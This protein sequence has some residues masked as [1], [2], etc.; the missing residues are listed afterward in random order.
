MAEQGRTVRVSGLPTD[1]EDDRLKD[2]LIIHFLRTRNG[3]GEID[4]V[5]IV[6]ARPV[7]ALITFEDSEVAHRVIQQSRHILDVD[8]KTYKLK[9]TEHHESLDPDE[10]I[11]NLS[12]TVDYS[13]LPGGRSALKSLHKSH[14]EV[15]IDY[16]AE[17]LCILSGA[18]SKVQAALAHLLG[19]PRPEEN[20]EAGRVESSSSRS[21][22]T[23]KTS[24]AQESEEQSQKPNKP[25]E[26]SEK[27]HSNRLSDENNAG[28]YRDLEPR[29]DS[30]ED[31][32]QPAAAELHSPEHPTT[33]EDDFPLIVDADMFQYLQKN[34]GKE[35]Q[36]I[37]SQYGVE[38]VDVTNQGLTTLYLQVTTGEGQGGQEQERVV[39][40]RKA[41][42]GLYQKNETKTRRSQLTKSILS[43][44]G[45]LQRAIESLK[46]KLPK[47]LLSEDDRNIY[48]IGSSSDVSEA[49]QFL[50]LDFDLRG[51]KEDVSSLRRYPSYDFSSLSP[52]DKIRVPVTSSTAEVPLN[53]RTD[54]VLRPEDDER[55]AEGAKKYKLAARF[56]DTGLSPLGNR[57]T[58]FSFRGLSSLSRPTRAGPMLGHDVLSEAAG[59]SRAESQNTGDDILFKGG[60]ALH[61]FA[62]MQNKTSL[63]SNVMDT[64]PKSLASTGS[65]TPPPAGSGSTLK[66]AN[67]FS[68]TPQQKAQV[69]SPKSQ[70][71][72]STTAA[73]ARGRS[74]SFSTQTAK[75]RREVHSADITVSQVMWQHIKEAYSAKVDD[76][77]SDVQIKEN[78]PDRSGDFTVTITGANPSI[79]SSCRL[80]LQKL[81]DLVQADFSVHVLHLS[82]L[83]VT[84][85]E[86]ETLQACCAEVQ[87]RFKKVTMQ[88][89]KKSLFLLGP[90]QLCSQVAATLQEVFSGDL[91][92]MRDHQDF[93]STRNPSTSLQLD[94]GH[95]STSLHYDSNPQVMLESTTG[96]ADGTGEGQVRKTKQMSEF[97]E[98][99]LMNGSV[100]QSSVRKDPVIKEKLKIT[101]TMEIDGHHSAAGN[102]VGGTVTHVNGVGSAAACTD[103]PPTLDKKER[104]VNSTQKE[105]TQQRQGQIQDA[106]ESGQGGDL[107]PGICVCGDTGTSVTRTKCGVSMCSKCMDKVHVHCKVCSEAD[108]AETPPGIRGKMRYS[109]LDINLPGHHRDA[110]VKITYN[111]PDG[112]QGAV[113]V[114]PSVGNQKAGGT[115]QHLSYLTSHVDV[116]RSDQRARDHPFP[117]KPFKGG[118]FEAF[119]P[120]CERTRTLLPRLEKAFKR[121]L[122]FT[123]K[124]K[125]T[126][127]KVIWDCIPHKTSLQGG[128]SG[129]GYPD[130][131]YLS[132][133]SQVLSSHGIEESP[134]K[135]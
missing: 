68:G 46:V 56:K 50:L 134:G 65:T 33:P 125:E 36:H 120:D 1:V 22:R 7:S 133:L 130:S 79:V 76:L 58:D 86:D 43:P 39:L 8:G 103:K 97:S 115:E 123:V 44:R 64:R 26:R 21:A 29:G 82:D 102:K 54:Q 38:V 66:R 18:F 110:A 81:V 127:A 105:S 14:P 135:S 59:I 129:N 80:S 122:T 126:G 117:G 42:S 121:G 99:E 51:K 2:K 94:K 49:K 32:G 112:I 23:T 3:G 132:R 19:G 74:S 15:Q 30:W 90:K 48:I 72:F 88:V 119:L 57:P 101:G 12:A 104:R 5:T 85:P 100:N 4:C 77:T 114:F 89:L 37:L 45:G 73:R 60:D 71:D 40:A 92:Q 95:Q 75:D 27:E 67:S 41:I 6:K 24:H 28:S 109:K 107:G 31:T 116:F 124:G 16:D 96:K 61:S 17:E 118:Q 69:T 70:D 25:R 62:L 63:N 98:T 53:D 84:D 87:S 91:T 128:K 78:R 108:R 9:V 52:A 13:Q 131:T 11:V 83:G 35:Y 106:P 47:L 113:S 93:I 111:I 20:K 55:R 10:V 34:C